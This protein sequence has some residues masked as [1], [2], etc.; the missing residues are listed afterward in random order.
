VECPICADLKYADENQDVKWKKLQRRRTIAMIQ[1]KEH[2]S[3][4]GE[5]G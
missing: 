3:R 1:T 2:K 5:R 4:V